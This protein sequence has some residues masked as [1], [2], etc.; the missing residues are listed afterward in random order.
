V[1]AYV[2]FD[3]RTLEAIA[4]R[5]PRTLD[6]LRAV[7]GIGPARAARYGEAILALVNDHEPP[8]AE[9]GPPSE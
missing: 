4:R 8:T 9:D 3:D 1:P 6:E 5:A 7:P 2:F